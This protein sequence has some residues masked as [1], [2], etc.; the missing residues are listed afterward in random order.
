ME[1]IRWRIVDTNAVLSQSQEDV[2]LRGLSVIIKEACLVSVESCMSSLE[3]C[4]E[5]VPVNSALA[6]LQQLVLGLDTKVDPRPQ[7]IPPLQLHVALGGRSHV[8]FMNS[9]ST[10]VAF[11]CGPTQPS[12]DRIS[13]E[14]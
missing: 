10:N 3:G 5:G 6:P 2:F 4:V 7:S 11:F 1:R 9:P 12:L 14:G 13:V 8:A